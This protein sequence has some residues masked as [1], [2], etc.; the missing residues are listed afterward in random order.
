MQKKQ[1]ICIKNNTK[2]PAEIFFILFVKFIPEEENIK[3]IKRGT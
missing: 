1:P 2:M 3:L